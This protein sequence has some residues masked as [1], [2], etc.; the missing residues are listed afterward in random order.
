[1]ETSRLE[2][3]VWQRISG[4]FRQGDKTSVKLPYK[5]MS[6]ESLNDAIFSEKSDV[7]GISLGDTFWT[8]YCMCENNCC[9][10]CSGPMV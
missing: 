9:P 5:W 8:T 10:M 1:M 6:I 2:T 3:L 4:Y 7:V